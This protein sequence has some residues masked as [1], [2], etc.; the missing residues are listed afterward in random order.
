MNIFYFDWEFDFL[1]FLQDIHN[2]VLDVIMKYA[3]DLGNLGLFWIL[4]AL[5]LVAIKSQ[6]KTGIQAIVAMALAFIVGNLILKN[7][8]MRARPC[9][10]DET[11]ALLVKIPSDYSFPSGHTMNGFATSISI[12][13]NNKKIGIPAVILATVITFSRLYNFVHFPTDIIGGFVIA[14]CM[15]IL[16]NYLCKKDWRRGKNNG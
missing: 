16:A 15:A 1:Y 4:V 3:S 11:V 9:Q 2:P 12:L 5:V 14:L 6:R 7:A 10:I 13:M 8:F